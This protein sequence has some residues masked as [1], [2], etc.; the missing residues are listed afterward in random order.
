MKERGSSDKA[1]CPREL[2]LLV[3]EQSRGLLCPRG[4][5]H[6]VSAQQASKPWLLVPPILLFPTASFLKSLYL[7]VMFFIEG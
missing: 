2:G 6:M 1:K 3:G 7:F 5:T 4:G